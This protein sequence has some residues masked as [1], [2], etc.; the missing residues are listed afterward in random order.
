[1]SEYQ[2]VGFRA[3]D[4]PV[5]EKD[6]DYMEAQSSRAEITAWS[7]DNE[8]HYG[9]FHGNATEMLRRGYD[10][11]LH[12]ANFGTRTLMIRLPQGLPDPQAAKPYLG[13]DLKFVKDKGTDAGILSIEPCFEPDSLDELW[14]LPDVVERLV[15]LRAEIIDGDLRPLYLAHLAIAL[16]DYHDPA[17]TQE[18][19][20]PAGLSKL[21][22]AQVALAELYGLDE[23]L[24]AAAA[25]M[26]P[27]LP[28][29]ANIQKQYADWLHQLPAANKD[30]L[31]VR[32]MAEPH[33]AVRRELLAD[34]QKRRESSPWPTVHS[35]RT[36]AGLLSAAK[37]VE[38][39]SI[40]QKTK[41]AARERAR[42]LARLATDPQPALRKTEVL[43]KER[44]TEGYRE[45]A[46]MLA[47]L[48]D[49]L[50]GTAQSDVAEKQA[51]RLKSAHPTL[52]VLV[53]EL[54]KQGFLKK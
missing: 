8:Y 17:E 2:Y 16:D 13:G 28:P 10:L 43:A 4:A 26:S 11:H 30:A 33:S 40:R 31:L 37:E 53:S 49:A 44:T 25:Q 21:S 36:I 1:M 14:D 54:R 6:L 19:P 47:D 48:R 27:A 7:F 12:Y 34:F 29:Q 3:I 20:V 22:A 35:T 5:S 18:P 38:E 32:L 9:D 42:K 52:K 15:P 50:A 45:I 41:K 23:H 46:Q 39:Q 51:V 24:L